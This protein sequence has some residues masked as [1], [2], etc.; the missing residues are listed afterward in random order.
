MANNQRIESALRLTRGPR[1]L[2]V[3]CADESQPDTQRQR[4]HWLHAALVDAGH[5]VLG[6]DINERG[7][8]W[9]KAAGYE[10]MVLDAES[11]PPAGE[12]F[13][14]IVAGE[15]IEHLANPGLFLNGAR[16]RL[17]PDG[18]LVLT[19]PNP[20]GVLYVLA[21]LKNYR[22]AFNPHHTCWFDAQTL[23]QLLVRCGYRVDAIEH[24]DDIRADINPSR[25]YRL[26]TAVW[27][28]V[29]WALPRRLRN[30]IVVDA[31]LAA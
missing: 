15:L 8:E 28:G 7:L 6:G 10:V 25:V 21:F 26:T 22:K 27:R 2:H 16:A 30:T 18:H 11:I 4:K 29:R 31:T 20:F 14:S 5:S 17:R 19:T 13:D 24:V 9:M 12:K 23:E 1:V 3:G